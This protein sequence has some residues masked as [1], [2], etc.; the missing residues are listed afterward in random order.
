M[1]TG[2]INQVT[3]VRRGDG[4]LPR[5]GQK[6]YKVTVAS[7]HECPRGCGSQPGSRQVGRRPPSAFPFRIPQSPVG[8]WAAGAGA[9]ETTA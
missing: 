9:P 2:R 8:R 6:R 4:R 1:T 3:I 7:G 5:E